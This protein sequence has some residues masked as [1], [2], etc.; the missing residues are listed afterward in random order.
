MSR[1][2]FLT[3]LPPQ[4][5]GIA[6]YSARVL[7]ALA[8]RVEVDV[9][10]AH[11]PVEPIPGV[12]IRRP[13]RRGFRRL[14][15]YD[16]VVAQVGNSVAHDWIVEWIRRY[17]STVVVHELVLHHLVG[18]MTLGRG[19]PAEYLRLL[20]D[21]A[22]DTAA[23]RGIRALSGLED[24][25]WETAADLYP[26][27][28]VAARHAKGL[29]VH[30]RFMAE[31]ITD[32]NFG[33]SIDVVPFPVLPVPRVAAKASGARGQ[34]TVGVFGFITSNK[35]LPVVLRALRLIESRVP[36]ARLLVVGESPSGLDVQELAR[37]IGVKGDRVEVHGY[38]D[39]DS[40]DTL[41][42]RVDLGICLR[43]PTFGETS[44]A[45]LDFMARG[46]PVVV[47]TGGWYDEL[48]DDAVVRV[49]PDA[50]E[51]L[52]LAATMEYL[53]LDPRRREAMGQASLE[54]VVRDLSPERTAD[55][56]I[57]AVLG[58]A[59]RRELEDVLALSLAQAVAAAAGVAEVETAP[60]S[61]AVGT[62]GRE[63]NLLSVRP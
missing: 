14:S 9:Y 19:K 53:A 5:N 35:R 51:V 61:A 58:E 46:I 41:V 23:K 37:E 30:S 43:H 27:T 28:G 56:Y 22:G 24:P 36:E 59:G 6:D 21:E 20:R 18:A 2:A 55:A 31:A 44:A 57:R 52:T 33:A 12:R 25:L 26:L 40:Y 63:L 60:L 17:P 10:C 50:D 13:T 1:I 62:A 32:R 54:F 47:S 7:T 49:A 48:P 29:I 8:R 16:A 4:H 11:R 34:L 38:A 15:S 45:T 42:A 39:H 3:P